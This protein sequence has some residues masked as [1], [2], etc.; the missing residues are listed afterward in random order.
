YR[1][2]AAAVIEFR[3]RGVAFNPLEKPDPDV[4]LSAAER[5]PGGLGIFM[6]KK[7]MD[8]VTYQRDNDE[9]V[10]TIRKNFTK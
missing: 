3:D 1:E 10:L 8:A 2:D 7:S 9:N 4:T 6:V 5:E